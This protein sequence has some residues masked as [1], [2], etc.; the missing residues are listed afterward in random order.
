MGEV[1][2]GDG[3]G[4]GHRTARDGKVAGE[5]GVDG[6]CD[7]ERAA[8]TI[9]GAGYAVE[10]EILAVPDGVVSAAVDGLLARHGLTIE[11]FHA[12]V[13]ELGVHG[14]GNTESGDVWEGGK[15]GIESAQYVESCRAKI[16][17]LDSWILKTCRVGLG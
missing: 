3:G 15:R 8:P 6:F 4:G 12:I 13:P 2:L 16:H 7:I 17:A 1:A 14:S 10:F 9:C 5:E 11:L